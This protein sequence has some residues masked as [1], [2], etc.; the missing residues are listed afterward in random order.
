M[1]YIFIKEHSSEFTVQK[2]CRVLKVSRSAYYDWLT[3]PESDKKQEDNNLLKKII[4][5]HEKSWCT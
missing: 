3:T 2:M 1:R 4:K 5:I